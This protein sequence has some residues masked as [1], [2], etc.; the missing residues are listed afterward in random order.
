M[1]SNTGR[2]LRTAACLIAWGAIAFLVTGCGHSS[3]RQTA[4][5]RQSA[6]L[7]AVVFVPVIQAVARQ[8]QHSIRVDPRPLR[9]DPNIGVFV[10]EEHFADAASMVVRQREDA[11]TELGIPRFQK[12]MLDMCG[13][14][15][16][17]TLPVIEPGDTTTRREWLSQP[18]LPTCVLVSLPRPGGVYFPPL[19]I[20]RRAASPGLWTVRVITI[21]SGQAVD[22]IDV[23]LRRG[24]GEWQLVDF[25]KLSS[26]RS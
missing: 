24:R 7:D 25:V 16:G 19:D 6:A 13:S 3:T 4:P 22:V 5:D 2:S 21:G 8:E 10:R 14:G 23:V 12:S 20:D 1:E 11:L 26:L 15:P 18:Q 17:G 9:P